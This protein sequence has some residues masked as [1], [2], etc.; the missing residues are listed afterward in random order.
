M[1]MRTNGMPR[2]RTACKKLRMR[3]DSKH[4]RMRKSSVYEPE[5]RCV[6]EAAMKQITQIASPVEQLFRLCRQ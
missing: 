4:V 1:R 3:T 6:H 5:T 2:M